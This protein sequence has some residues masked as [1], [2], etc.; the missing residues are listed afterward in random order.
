[1]AESVDALVSNTSGATRPGSTPGLG[2]QAQKSNPLQARG[3]QGIFLF[4]DLHQRKA[5]VCHKQE[6]WT[7][8]R[9]QKCISLHRQSERLALQ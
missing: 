9:P 6:L 8:A 1:M 7:C 3:L 4:F 2:T 5:D